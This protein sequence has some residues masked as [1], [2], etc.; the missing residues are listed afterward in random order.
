MEEQTAWP[1]PPSTHV[2][3]PRRLEWPS[4]R[5]GTSTSIWTDVRAGGAIV[6]TINKRRPGLQRSAARLSDW[7]T[8]TTN[9]RRASRLAG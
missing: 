3:K 5:P 1:T 6:L 9:R 7:R 4:M 2:N 8:G